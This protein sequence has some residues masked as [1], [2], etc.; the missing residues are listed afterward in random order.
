MDMDVLG[1]FRAEWPLLKGLAYRPF[2]RMRGALLILIGSTWL[3]AGAA[4]VTLTDNGNGTVTMANGLVAMT[5]GKADG[6]VSSFTTTVNP[7]FNMIDPGQDYALSLT[8]IGSGT[9]DYWMSINSPVN[10]NFIVVTNT[11]QIVDVLLD[12]PVASG[13]ASLFPNGIWDWQEHHIM[14]AGEAGFYTYHVWKHT[15]NKP[16]AYF[17]ADSWQGRGSAL[18]TQQQNAD[19]SVSNAWAFSGSDVPPA[20]SIG[21]IPGGN[22]DGVPGEVE[23][24]PTTNIWTQP[25]GTNYEPGWP[26]FTQPTGLT[27]YLLPTW[28]KYDYS[29][30]LGA[31]NAFRPV[32]GMS[33]ENIGMWTILA[34]AEHLCAC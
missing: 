22:S 30:Y 5:F 25:T 19:G 31:S 10:P 16:A 13:N 27:S 23:V 3:A 24:L 7:G 18:F 26:A 4:N 12:N 15:A 11:G 28:T 14:R 1:H 17:D 29:S 9:N 6:S 20:L 21:E 32:W 34:S 2:S 8:H 33:T